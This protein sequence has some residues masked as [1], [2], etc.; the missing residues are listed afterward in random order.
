MGIVVWYDKL[1]VNLFLEGTTGVLTGFSSRGVIGIFGCST[2]L[3]KKEG[4]TMNRPV[5]GYNVV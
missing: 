2:L 1:N 4:C 3:W 5:G